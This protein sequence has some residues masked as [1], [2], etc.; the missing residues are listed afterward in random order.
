MITDQSR[1]C[2]ADSLSAETGKDVWKTKNVV[3]VPE[4]SVTQSVWRSW[5]PGPLCMCSLS[6]VLVEHGAAD[7]RRRGLFEFRSSDS[8]VFCAIERMF[9][10][11]LGGRGV[12]NPCCLRLTSAPARFSPLAPL[13][14][15][16][17]E[18]MPPL[19]LTFLA[20]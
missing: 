6:Q 13:G 3:Y 8:S 10:W 2:S 9:G 1:T 20:R 19:A 7:L 17:R 14:K 18:P 15:S 12:R 11:C 16:L 4:S 5:N